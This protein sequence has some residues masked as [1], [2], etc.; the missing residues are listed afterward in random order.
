[1]RAGEHRHLARRVDA[2]RAGF[3]EPGLS[4][5]RA[6]HLGGRD[7]AGLDV[8][9]EADAEELAA[10]SGSLL[11]APELLVVEHAEQL[12]EGRAIVAAVIGQRDVGLVARVELRDEILLA[13]LRGVHLESRR[14]RVHDPLDEIRGLRPSRTAIGVDR[15][16]VGEDA[17]DLAVDGAHLVDAVQQGAV[18]I[19]RDG[20]GESRQ[21]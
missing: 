12:V 8:G 17:R 1:M 5:E 2:H 18:E 15:R 20:G 16:R 9:R 3:P 14:P 6:H 11:V 13:E 21:V 4:A 19:C 10:R 7:A